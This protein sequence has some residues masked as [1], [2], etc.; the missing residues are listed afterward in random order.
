MLDLTYIRKIE[1]QYDSRFRF[2]FHLS[3]FIMSSGQICTEWEHW[4]VIKCKNL[5]I[6]GFNTCVSH[7]NERSVIFSRFMETE[8][9]KKLSNYQC[10]LIADM[11]FNECV[12]RGKL[13]CSMDELVFLDPPW[14]PFP[15]ERMPDSV[16]EIIDIFEHKTEL[17]P[18][19]DGNEA[20][21][22]T[23]E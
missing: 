16:Q 22:P 1:S 23:G 13:I 14:N 10:K 8:F 6:E 4:P 9:S 5:K 15:T 20:S 12:R 2:I 21:N 17:E 18:E 7:I 19:P 3:S 11:M